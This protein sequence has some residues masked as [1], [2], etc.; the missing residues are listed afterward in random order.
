MKFLKDIQRLWQW[1]GR[2]G[3]VLFVALVLNSLLFNFGGPQWLRNIAGITATVAG[4]V[5]S[6]KLILKA[7]RHSIWRL[8]N[9]LIVTYVFIGLVPILLIATLTLLA[10]WAMSGQVAVYLITSEFNRRMESL[11]GTAQFILREPPGRRVERVKQ[12]GAFLSENF[13]DLKIVLADPQRHTFPDAISAQLPTESWKDATGL[14]S[15]NGEIHGWVNVSSDRGRIM[16]AAKKRSASLLANGAPLPVPVGQ[17]PAAVSG[18]DLEVLWASPTQISDFDS[19][20]S[21]MPALFSVRTRISAVGRVLLSQKADWDSNWALILIYAFG[22]LFLVIEIVALIVGVS[23][24]R[25]I[26]NT[27]HDLYEGTERVKE[28]DFSHRI[29]LKGRDQLAQLGASF[30]GMTERVE[31]LLQVAKEKERYEAELEIA[32]EIQKQLYPRQV[33]ASPKLKLTALYKPA[34]MVSGDYYDY[35]R[36]ASDQLVLA[37]GDVAGKGISA[38]LLM[39][40][41]QSSFRTQIKTCME[42]AA[43]AAKATGSVPVCNLSTSQ[44]TSLLN[45][46]LYTNTPPEKFAT[47]VFGVFDETTNI[48]H[49]TNAGHLQPI[50]I[51]RGEASLLEV[52]GMVIGAFPFA[53]YGESQIAMEP[54]DLLVFYTDGISEPENEYGEMYGEQRLTE[55]LVKNAGKSDQ[56]ILDMIIDAVERWTGSPELQDDMTLLVARCL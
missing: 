4:L 39:A 17:V 33:P 14:V 7:I 53:R 34:R 12:I 46:H 36:L 27:V 15:I 25:S 49:Y 32:R 10:L 40:T 3:Q 20:G 29:R 56:E 52:D 50:L 22:V 28:G 38:A 47:F 31:Q 13:P 11:R 51:R 30:N 9:R 1:F 43:V 54:G 2:W 26:T 24:T 23:L 21:N 16:I 37:L 48:F 42:Q 18:W 45:Q 6:A 44:L 19:P 55:L 35:Q 5:V 8:R 41:I